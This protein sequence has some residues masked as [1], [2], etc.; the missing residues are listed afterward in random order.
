MAAYDWDKVSKD[1]VRHV[2][3]FFKPGDKPK[4]AAAK[5][6]LVVDAKAFLIEN[7]DRIDEF[8]RKLDEE[9]TKPKSK[10]KKDEGA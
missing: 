6:A 9:A 2:L 3:A 7:P 5:S 8:F 10:T 4:A 1:A